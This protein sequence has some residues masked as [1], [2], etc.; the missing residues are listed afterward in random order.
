MQV[1]LWNSVFL[2]YKTWH[3]PTEKT[4]NSVKQEHIAPIPY[5]HLDTENTAKQEHI[6]AIPYPDTQPALLRG[7]LDESTCS[8]IFRFFRQKNR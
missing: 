6:A 5:P 4:K 8:C 7:E 3:R 1:E 2:R